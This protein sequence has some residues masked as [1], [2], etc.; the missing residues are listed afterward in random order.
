MPARGVMAMRAMGR[1][2]PQLIA[3]LLLMLVWEASTHLFQISPDKLPS[4][5]SVLATAW[6]SRAALTDAVSVTLV[7][8]LIGLFAGI[9][10]GVLSG[11]AFSACRLL[12]RMLLPYVI[13]SQA[14]PIIAFGAIIIIWFGNGIA[15]KALIAFYLSFFPVAVNTLGGIRR[16]SQDEVG[17]LRTFGASRLT[18][19]WKLQL[20]TALPSIFTA[21]RIGVGLALIGAI[22]GEW[23]GSSRGLGVVLLTSMFDN[24]MQEL[25]AGIL[26]TGL[27][28]T[29]LFWVVVA[30]QRKI[31]WW[32][33]EV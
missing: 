20:P 31:A 29:A 10:F 14:V 15:S 1:I 25:W 17:L 7:E 33:A 6:S 32:Q 22:V 19:L 16:V 28:G 8:T 23:F 13:A 3:V 11:I 26:L 5:S 12:E 24:Q 2:A 27:T 18:I 30:F 9:G 21:I 4:L